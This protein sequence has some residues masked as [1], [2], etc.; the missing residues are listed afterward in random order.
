MPNPLSLH[1]QWLPIS[2]VSMPAA[3]NHHLARIAPPAWLKRHAPA[4]LIPPALFLLT[5]AFYW[6]LVFTDQ[7]TW[8]ES[9]DLAN[10]VLPW[11]QFQAGEWRQGVLPLWDP[12]LWSGQ[13]LIGQAQ[14]G[15][16]YPLNWLLFLRPLRDGWM[17]LLWLH[18]Y[19]VLIHFM[20]VLFAYWLARDLG[21]SRAAASLAG[22]AFGLGGYVG[23]TDWPQM[24][25]GA[26][27]APLVLLYLRRAFVGIRPAA[28]AALAGVFLGMAWL[29]GHHQIPIYTTLAA[30]GVCAYYVLRG[31]RPCM[32]AAG[33]TAL[34]LAFTLLVGALQ[35]L[36]AYEYGKLA[37]RW[38]GVEEPVGWKE[39]VPYTVHAEYSLNPLSV[40]GIVIPGVH[41]HANPFAGVVVTALAL[42]ALAL[43]FGRT[44][45]RLLAAVAAGGLLFSLGHN[46]VWHG[47]LYA[48]APL[49]EKARTPSMAIFVF[50]FGFS[51]LAALGFDCL[52]R[53]NGSAWPRRAA[54]ALVA[55]AALLL[56]ACVIALVAGKIPEDRYALTALMALLAAGVIYGAARGALSSRAAFAGLLVL[57]L[58]EMGQVSGFAFAHRREKHRS[59]YLDRMA[60]HADIVEF[61]RSQPW[62]LRVAYSDQHIPYNIGDW[63]GLDT[64]GGYVAS[65]PD[66][67]LRLGIHSRRVHDLMG[68]GYAI[69][70]QPPHP[71]YREIFQ[72]RS[73]LKVYLNP[74]AMPRA[75][76][77]HS[78]VRVESDEQA[79]AHLENPAFEFG[80]AGWIHGPAPQLESCPD[81]PDEVRLLRRDS[82][83]LEI[84]A[85]MGCRGMVVVSENHFPGWR[86][87][88]D[89]RPVPIHEVYTCLRGVVVERGLHR[90][91]MEYRPRSVMLGAACTLTGLLAAGFLLLRARRRDQRLLN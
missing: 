60:Q 90:I 41:R 50:H 39:K 5:T 26:V 63:Y 52:F 46:S 51:M 79:R 77:T 17:R 44:E 74:K 84:E 1:S 88:V 29:G 14:P 16:A 86:A 61:L 28:S 7:Y 59:V 40:L 19:F 21:A 11:L 65:L 42:L 71:D 12:Y 27:W 82:Q 64:F 24:L 15:V 37:R 56:A 75:W 47:M 32:K 55:W 23:T 49:V 33:L 70:E 45:V 62:P 3:E 38:V 4:V 89:G 2:W 8:L 66:N 85:R 53:S 6:K 34:F 87:T 18:W 31:F 36:P 30:L 35:I 13:S 48:V 81:S 72:S 69:G 57:L 68:V 20:A 54:L 58:I 76:V 43:G 67:L 80:A 22:L 25:N 73:G 91:R 78:L 9:P 83:S 10:Q